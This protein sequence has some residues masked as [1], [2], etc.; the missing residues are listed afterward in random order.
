MIL[1]CG[2]VLLVVSIILLIVMIVELAKDIDE[3]ESQV[4]KS[5]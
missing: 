4:W 3:G 1:A 2:V 5:A